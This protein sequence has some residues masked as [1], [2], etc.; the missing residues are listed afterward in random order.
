M[1]AEFQELRQR[2]RR[3][4]AEIARAFGRPEPPA[5]GPFL[6]ALIALNEAACASDRPELVILADTINK[7]FTLEVRLG[8][9]A[10]V[11]VSRGI[12]RAYGRAPAPD[13]PE[14]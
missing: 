10:V 7:L 14:P 3:A 8:T 11:A 6:R 5:A 9:L 1:S 2:L 13:T 12:D 4:N